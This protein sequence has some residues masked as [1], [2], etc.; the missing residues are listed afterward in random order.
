VTRSTNQDY[1]EQLLW[2][3]SK[4]TTTVKHYR[5][6]IVDQLILMFWWRSEEEKR[7]EPRKPLPMTNW[8]FLPQY[9][10]ES[11][12]QRK[13]GRKRHQKR[14]GANNP[15]ALP[16]IK[17]RK[18]QTASAV[19]KGS[20]WLLIQYTPHPTYGDGDIVVKKT[21]ILFTTLK[22]DMPHLR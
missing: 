4:I 5:Q 11:K 18:F 10:K 9:R 8:P 21:E 22:Q 12:R 19:Q 20:Q 15:T 3:S 14:V 1:Y 6:G 2:N 13:T 16:S 7:A 17:P